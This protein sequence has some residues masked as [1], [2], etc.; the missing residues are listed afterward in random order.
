MAREEFESDLAKLQANITFG[1]MMEQVR[2]IVNV[3]LIC[4]LNKLTKAVSRPTFHHAEIN[5]DLTLVC[6]ACQRFALNKPISVG[7][8]ILE[9]SK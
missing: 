5:N 7:F 2:N 8:C 3:C 6:G 9:I 4:D 1:K